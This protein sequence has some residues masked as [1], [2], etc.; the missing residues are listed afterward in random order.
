[1]SWVAVGTAAVTVIGGAVAGNQAK[2]GAQGAAN[3]QERANQLAIEEQRR[4]YDLTR[5]DLM[6]YMEYGQQAIPALQRLMSGDYSGFENSPDY[7]WTTQ[8]GIGRLDD[9]A[10]SRGSLFSGGH[11]K[12]LVQFNQGNASQFLN[13]YWN[14]LTNQAASGQNAAA[15]LGG[16]GQST[17]NAI[18]SA[19]GNIGNAQAGALNQIGQNN[20]QLTAGTFG[21]LGNLWG[22]YMG[23]RGTQAAPQSGFG[24][25]NPNVQGW[26]SGQAGGYTG[27][28]PQTGS[29][30]GEWGNW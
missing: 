27:F 25:F 11:Q 18:G 17:A 13:N 29:A 6:P 9:S 5:G 21:A 2:K 16:I 28:N 3:A 1:M 14:R 30:F 22:N 8:Q 12:D 26:N 20:A 10:A 15:G 7:L 19:Y 4:Q 23:N 24:A